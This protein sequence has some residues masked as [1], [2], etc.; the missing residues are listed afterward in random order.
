MAAAEPE[1]LTDIHGV[2]WLKIADDESPGT[3]YYY[4]P[5]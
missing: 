2:K 4:N 3:F 1:E 5:A